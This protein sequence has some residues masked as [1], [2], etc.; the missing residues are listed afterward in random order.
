MP[1]L[2]W[3]P[4]PPHEKN[5]QA[6]GGKGVGGISESLKKLPGMSKEALKLLLMCEYKTTFR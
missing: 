6:R 3:A 4:L 2:Q 1:V 5:I